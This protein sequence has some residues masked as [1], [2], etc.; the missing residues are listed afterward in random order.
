MFPRP[1]EAVET[2]V[3]PAAVAVVAVEEMACLTMG[4]YIIW[5]LA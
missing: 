5:G 1:I 2:V 4:P 3:G